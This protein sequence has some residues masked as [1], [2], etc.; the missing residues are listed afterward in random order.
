VIWRG[1]VSLRTFK[2]ESDGKKLRI[3][4]LVVAESHSNSQILESHLSI[5][6]LKRLCDIFVCRTQLSLTVVDN[7]AIRSAH[8]FPSMFWCPGTHWRCRLILLPNWWA[9]I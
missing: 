8:S 2:D 4:E 6:L 5:L 3:V 7:L 9:R 1:G